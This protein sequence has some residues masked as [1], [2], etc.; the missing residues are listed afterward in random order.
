MA[1]PI[2]Y[3]KVKKKNKIEFKKIKKGKKKRNL[4]K[5]KR[6]LIVIKKEEHLLSKIIKTVKHGSSKLKDSFKELIQDTV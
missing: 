4:K 1:K 3:C 6:M 2:Q 5:K